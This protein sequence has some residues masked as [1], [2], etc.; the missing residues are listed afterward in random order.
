MESVLSGAPL[1]AALDPEGAAALRASMQEVHF[2]KGDVVFAEGN[3]TDYR[4]VM[5]G[6]A[7][8]TRD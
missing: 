4:H 1:F 8:A 2:G 5:R 7:A 3:L 6:D